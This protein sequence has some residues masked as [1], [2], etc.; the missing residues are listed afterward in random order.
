MTWI[1]DN[2]S[3]PGIRPGATGR[4]RG[5]STRP[6]RPDGQSRRD[7]AAQGRAL[8]D[9]AV[10]LGHRRDGV[11][12][13]PSGPTGPVQTGLRVAREAGGNIGSARRV[14]VGAPRTSIRFWTASTPEYWRTQLWPTQAPYVA[15]LGIQ[16]VTGD[17]VRAVRVR[18]A[19]F[20]QITSRTGA[21]S[22]SRTSARN[23]AASAP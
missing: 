16:P 10:R 4:G 12:R 1:A 14:A 22:R 5:R 7:P 17:I 19:P 23:R 18:L 2:T 3:C 9:H 11:M 15:G 6:A 8:R 21:C 20:S 13:R